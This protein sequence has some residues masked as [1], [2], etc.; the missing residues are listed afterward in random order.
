VKINKI[1]ICLVIFIFVG[2]NADAA[3]IAVFLKVRG[4]TGLEDEFK[5]IAT[6][7][8]LKYPMVQVVDNKEESHLYLEFTMVEQDPIK[9]YAV[10][11]AI[12]YHIKD[13]FYSRPMSDVAQFGRERM[14]DICEFLVQEIDKAFLVPL[15]TPIE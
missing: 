1:I 4:Q 8:F 10:G 5:E 2:I 6:K 13:D 11:V 3:N 12:S 14:N 9:L 15:R 7:E